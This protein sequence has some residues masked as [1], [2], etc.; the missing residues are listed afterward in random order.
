MA[1]FGRRHYE[2][3]S[4]KPGFKAQRAKR[5][6][7]GRRDRQDREA[8]KEIEDFK[9]NKAREDFEEK[10]DHHPNIDGQAPRYN[11]KS[12]MARGASK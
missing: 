6:H 5:V 1:K 3:K 10:Q 7:R 11:S 2:E 9:V 8:R 12:R 4:E